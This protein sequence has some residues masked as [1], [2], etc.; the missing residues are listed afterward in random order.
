MLLCLFPCQHDLS[1]S[2]RAALTLTSWPTLMTDP[3]TTLVSYSLST[4]SL[5]SLCGPASDPKPGGSKPCLSLFCPAIGCR[6]LYS[7]NSFKLRS[8]FTYHILVY[9]RISWCLEA[10]R[11]WG[12]VFIITV[13][14]NRPSLSNFHQQN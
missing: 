2:A 7:T 11:P 3:F 4:F 6:H 5:L 12:P 13:H 8:K 14:S 10:T 1:G 9:M